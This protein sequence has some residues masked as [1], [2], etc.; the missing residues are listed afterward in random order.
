MNSS[1]EDNLVQMTEWAKLESI[2]SSPPRRPRQ[3]RA[4]G[5]HRMNRE[6]LRNVRR[7][8]LADGQ[9]TA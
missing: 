6:P 2:R 3:G 7:K 4:L 9:E 1:A 8:G 5:G